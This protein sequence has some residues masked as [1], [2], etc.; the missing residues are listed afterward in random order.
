[1]KVVKYI[2]KLW[3]NANVIILRVVVITTMLILF[4]CFR[5][6]SKTPGGSSIQTATPSVTVSQ[7]STTPSVTASK[8]AEGHIV[9]PVYHDENRSK[10]DIHI[11]Y[12]EAR[13]S[14]TAVQKVTYVNTATDSMDEL[15]LHIYPNHFSKQEYIPDETV[16]PDN[17][18]NPGNITFTSVKAAGQAIDYSIQ[19]KGSTILRIL[20]VE[21]GNDEA[22]KWFDLCVYGK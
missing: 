16:Y 13:H 10:Y 21:M 12:D 15:Y 19:G 8:E 3:L 7:Q 2:K 17:K 4:S 9:K 6:D 5:L 14:A 18:F 22:V 11:V 20:V 1:M